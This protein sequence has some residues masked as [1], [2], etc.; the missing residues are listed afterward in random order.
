M[1][2]SVFPASGFWGIVS[3]RIAIG[4]FIILILIVVA[5]IVA[6]VL[7]SLH[8]LRDEA[9][10]EGPEPNKKKKKLKRSNNAPRFNMLNSIDRNHKHLDPVYKNDTIT[11][12]AFCV[13]FRNFAA[14]K[15]GLYYSIDDVRRFVCGLGTSKLLILQGVSGT[16][17]TSLAYAMGEFLQNDAVVVPVQPMWKER[18]DIIGYFNEFTKRFNETVLLRKMYEAG[19]CKKMYITILDEVNIS[20]IEYYFAEFLSLLELPD[21]DKR[22]LDVVSDVWK[23]DPEL[24]KNGQIKLPP[25]MWFIGTA[26]NDDSTFAISDKVY[27]R[28]MILSLDKKCE[29]FSAPETEPV[30][31]SYTHFTELIE[32]AKQGYAM[33]DS[34]AKKIAALD[35][36]LIDTFHVSFGNRIMRQ[37]SE[38][39][40][41]YMACGGTELE[42]VDYLL[43]R[44]VLRKLESQN[45]TFI[46]NSVDELTARMN[47][48]F[49]EGKLVECSAYLARIKQGM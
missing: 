49:G 36:F 33:S 39:V 41:I 29:P 25:N 28:A 2:N 22:Y 27:D 35:T 37:I 44:K 45:P 43:A 15:L 26:N 14:N 16:G 20:R 42:A 17:K 8:I 10:L 6:N 7:V 9:E 23:N 48:I 24:L 40:P 18:S 46:K 30:L 13:S 32:A 3:S 34:C 38:Y 21:E 47:E 1:L 11:L 19:Y 31:V 5:V 12:E 4:L